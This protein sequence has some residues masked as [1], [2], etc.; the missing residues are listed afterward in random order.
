MPTYKVVT[1]FGSQKPNSPIISYPEIEQ[2]LNEGWQIVDKQFS[3]SQDATAV[4]ITF[5][6]SH[7]EKKKPSNNSSN[8][9]VAM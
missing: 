2:L 6:L 9:V 4:A 3:A 5:I 8:Y 7:T 1:A